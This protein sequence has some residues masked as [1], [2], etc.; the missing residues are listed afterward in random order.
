[1]NTGNIDRFPVAQLPDRYT[2][3]RS[4]VYKRL[5]VLGIQSLKIGNKAFIN[6]EQLALMDDLHAF[7]KDGGNA[8]E[9]VDMRGLAAQNSNNPASTG[10]SPGQ[11]PDQS[12]N[13]AIPGM[14]QGLMGM[15]AGFAANMRPSTPADKYRFLE[16]AVRKGWRIPSSELAKLFGVKAQDVEQYRQSGFG[17][18]GFRFMPNGRSLS[19]E[20]TWQI[21]KDKGRGLQF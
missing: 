19:G 14:N 16:E 18:S 15:L 4:A 11:S 20:T 1:M 3:A 8:A 6:A 9:F 10:Q 13:L 17:E 21:T 5:E 7:V 2:L 12:S